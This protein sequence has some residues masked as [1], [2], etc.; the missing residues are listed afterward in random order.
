MIPYPSFIDL[1]HLTHWILVTNRL[2]L[3]SMKKP[4]IPKERKIPDVI[5]LDPHVGGG[6]TL[7]EA[8]AAA[9]F[10]AKVKT[11]VYSE[12]ELDTL[13]DWAKSVAQ[14]VDTIPAQ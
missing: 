11:M 2:L 4:S 9:E 1:D 12:N 10:V 13:D 7:V 6:T 5:V 8:A 14:S 3:Q